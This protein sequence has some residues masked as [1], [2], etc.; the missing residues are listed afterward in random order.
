[1]S[2]SD[3]LEVSFTFTPEFNQTVTVQ[4]DGRI[5]LRS[6]SAVTAEGKTAA[7]LEESIRAAYAGILHEPE[8]TVTLKDF[9]KPFFIASGEVTHPGKY[10]LRSQTTVAEAVAIA[11]GFNLQAKHS[12]VILFRRVSPELV[13]ARVVDVKRI[14]K[15]KDLNEDVTLQAGDF[16]VV[17]KSL[18]VERDA[19]HAGVEH[20]DVPDVGKLLRGLEERANEAA[21]SPHL[22]ADPGMSDAGQH[23]CELETKR[24]RAALPH[25]AGRDGGVVPP[26]TSRHR[27]LRRS[28]GGD[29]AV[30][31][32]DARLSGAHDHPAA[33][34]ACRSG[35]HVGG[36][37]ADPVGT[38]R[39]E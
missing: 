20:G 19:I 5:A 25:D 2:K 11:G 24:R 16:L 33:A 34:G 36:E 28:A 26:T 7:E 35:C 6:T 4:P 38:R 18:G 15:E 22:E 14:L 32:R 8:V 21:G 31:V 17:P 3:V 37:W 27:R 10:E 1:L 13:E 30:L 12:Q 39:G 29:C 9:D 23:N